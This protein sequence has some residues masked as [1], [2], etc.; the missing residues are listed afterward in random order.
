MTAELSTIPEAQV[1]TDVP[2]EATGSAGGL[3]APPRARRQYG[4]VIGL[5]ALLVAFSVAHPDTFLTW[6]NTT[7]ILSES[8]ILAILAVG[9]TVPLAAGDFDLSIAAVASLAGM[10]TAVLVSDDGWGVVPTIAACLA[11]GLL[12][13]VI[14]GLLVAYVK[15]NAFVATLAMMSVLEGLSIGIAGETYRGALPSSL[16]NVGRTE[17]LGLPIVVYLAGVIALVLWFIMR[18]TQ[19]GRY[20]YSTG[21]SEIASRVAGVD[22][23]RVRLGAFC[24]SGLLAALAGT[25]MVARSGSAYPEGAEGLLLPAYAAAFVGSS[26]LSDNRFHIGGTIVG[27]ILL[28]AGQDGLIMSNYPQWLTD[29]FNGAVLALAV[30]L[31]RVPPGIFKSLVRSTAT[32]WRRA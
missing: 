14:N 10:L 26:V 4:V 15:I 6:S 16:T 8:A 23:S 30:G 5:V 1:G 2:D 32:R 3:G 21:S 9:L 27:V 20:V 19:F 7:S 13:G 11:A 28:Q 17:L 31:S 12:V 18:A 25:M 29:V 24:I 22:T